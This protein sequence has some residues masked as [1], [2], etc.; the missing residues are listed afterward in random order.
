LYLAGTHALEQASL[1]Q[2]WAIPCATDIAFSYMVA[3][4]LFGAKHPAIPF[5]LLL[6]IV[7]DAVG[8]VILALFY[9]TGD[10]N[11]GM[12]ALLLGAAIAF[13]MIL[14]RKKVQSFPLYLV[15][16]GPLA[17][18][19]F[20]VG[21]VHTAL[22][23]V[24]LIPT[25]PHEAHDEGLFKELDMPKSVEPKDALNRF[26]RWWKNPVEFILG[27]FG[28]VNAGVLLSN[29]GL[30]TALVAGSL[31][32]GKPLGITLMTLFA[33]KALKL[34]LPKGLPLSAVPVLGCIAGIGFTVALFVSTV[35]FPPGAILDAAKMGALASFASAFSALLA[36]RIARIQ[37]V[38]V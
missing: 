22:A 23:L 25:M 36:A 27:A 34:E 7:D 13:N 26:S 1:A 11:L 15:V 19:A 9:P 38:K 32:V 29:V 4:L 37:K 20:H 35:A 10:S 6:A 17:W 18:W 30:P 3:R 33:V 21:G 24:P 31:I 14:R 5:L 16:A 2:G 12:F 8:L 28:F